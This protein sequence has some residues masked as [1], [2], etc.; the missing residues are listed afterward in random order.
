MHNCTGPDGISISFDAPRDS[1]DLVC[2]RVR[3]AHARRAPA[4]REKAY[5]L[6]CPYYPLSHPLTP[7]GSLTPPLE[8]GLG[9]VR[10]G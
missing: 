10:G 2:P 5:P 8:E 4:A 6:R 1:D 9:G 3:T 7:P